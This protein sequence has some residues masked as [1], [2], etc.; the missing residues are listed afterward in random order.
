M[1][2]HRGWDTCCRRLSDSPLYSQIGKMWK[3]E[4]KL[5]VIL[6]LRFF[7]VQYSLMVLVIFRKI[8]LFLC[9]GLLSL[10]DFLSSKFGHVFPVLR[11][12]GR[13]RDSVLRPPPPR[14]ARARSLPNGEESWAGGG[15]KEERKKRSSTSDCTTICAP[16]SPPPPRCLTQQ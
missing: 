7:W 10:S 6:F 8:V 2:T 3:S 11:C 9:L 14:G 13:W 5:T 4:C 15:Q 12:A 1:M 16:R